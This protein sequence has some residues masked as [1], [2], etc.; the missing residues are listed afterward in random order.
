MFAQKQA[1]AGLLLNDDLSIF[2]KYT[3]KNISIRKDISIAGP[4]FP[5][6]REFFGAGFYRAPPGKQLIIISEAYLEPNRT[7]I[8]S[9]LGRWFTAKTTDVVI[10]FMIHFLPAP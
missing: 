3:L 10:V 9:V 6:F 2:V 8:W 1:S 4:F 7:L 5:S